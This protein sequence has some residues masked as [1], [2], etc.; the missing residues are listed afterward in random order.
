M[1]WANMIFTKAQFVTGAA[2]PIEFADS[3]PNGFYQYKTPTMTLQR[4][5]TWLLNEEW[6]WSDEFDHFV[7]GNFGYTGALITGKIFE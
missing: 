7:Y 1:I 2:P 3:I 4:D 5:G 6:Y